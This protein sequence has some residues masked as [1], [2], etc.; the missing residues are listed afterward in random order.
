M[1]VYLTYGLGLALAGALINL[2]MYFAGFHNDIGR[3]QTGQYIA[4]GL[5]LT[6]AFVGLF[7]GIRATREA[8][9]D[10]SLSYGRGVF[11]GLMIGVF[12]G[13][14]GAVFSLLYGLVI[15][16]EFHQLLY[17]MQMD[18]LAEAGVPAAQADKMEGMMRFFSGPW[19]IA[20]ASVFF[21][22]IFNV[23]IAL[24]LSAFLKRA[25]QPPAFE[26]TPAA[27]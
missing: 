15:N 25:P 2:A 7:L 27:G 10:K 18:K 22:P 4:S 16:P 8:A 6:V 26:Q 14:F 24:I 20:I 23:V 5:G 1:K 13:L 12:S 11:A 3:I 21:A 19:W 17:E 9:P